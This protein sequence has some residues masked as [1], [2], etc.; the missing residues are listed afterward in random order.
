MFTTHC[1][2][3]QPVLD[4]V[5][6]RRDSAG[7][8]LPRLRPGQRHP[9]RLP[10]VEGQPGVGL[11]GLGRPPQPPIWQVFGCHPGQGQAGHGALSPDGDKT[12]MEI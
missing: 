5:Q 4:D 12:K 9:L 7:R 8:H 10:R 11:R 2:G 3:W 6:S 1:S